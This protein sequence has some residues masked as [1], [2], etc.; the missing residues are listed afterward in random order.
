[1]EQIANIVNNLT[2]NNTGGNPKSFYYVQGEDYYI[3][4]NKLTGGP[5]LNLANGSPGTAMGLV[6]HDDE[7]PLQLDTLGPDE[8]WTLK[9]PPKCVLLQMHSPKH[10]KLQ[11]SWSIR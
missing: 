10:K 5:E 8:I 9:F 6:L 2:P 4:N 3:T 7:P 11:G 1:M